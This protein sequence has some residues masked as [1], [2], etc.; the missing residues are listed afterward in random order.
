[1]VL[2]TITPTIADALKRLPPQREPDEPAASEKAQ[3][4]T[5]L[6]DVT[7]PAEG[8]PI[9]H[10]QILD[11]WHRAA[12]SGMGELT[13]Q[14]LLQG[15]RVY[16][17]PPPPK[18]EPPQTPE[19]KALMARLREEEEER[20]YQRMMHPP[21]IET[22]S[23]QYPNAAVFAEINRARPAD[24][25]SA[26]EDTYEEIQR[27]LMLIV[28]FLI[29]I[30]GVAATLWIV[31]RWWS[32]PARLALSM[33]G[34]IVVA[35]TEVAVY[36]AFVWRVDKSEQKSKSADKRIKEV[37]SVKESWTLGRDGQEQEREQRGAKQIETDSTAGT[38][39][40]A[41]A[42]A[43]LQVADQPQALR[44]RVVAGENEAS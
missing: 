14:R 34:A 6:P 18:P 8:S 5:P 17:P 9:A 19:F 7:C 42:T 40:G 1:M 31:A 33:G 21:K 10:Q 20:K 25:G 15:T 35:I 11:L 39:A 28:N 43:S 44:R 4:A 32:T 29:S 13:L 38:S 26:D 2:L 3:E 27:Q 37:R 12:R 23:K 36:A 16:V 41:A 30:A 24:I 22:L